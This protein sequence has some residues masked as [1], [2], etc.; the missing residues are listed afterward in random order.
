[1]IGNPTPYLPW[2]DV[3]S[4]VEGAH[5]KW[6]GVRVGHS[7]QLVI[8]IAFILGA[9]AGCKKGFE[10]INAN[11]KSKMA[12]SC[13]PTDSTR[14]QWDWCNTNVIAGSNIREVCYGQL[15][16]SDILYPALLFKTREFPNGMCLF[17]AG[18]G[19]NGTPSPGCDQII[20]RDYAFVSGPTGQN[21]LTECLSSGK[22]IRVSGALQDQ[23][24]EFVAHQP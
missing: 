3:L 9:S 19:S 1:M 22:V 4:W 15:V 17:A 24:T 10:P 14:F 21:L 13:L 16:S 18:N 23:R 5:P 20:N 11:D 12:A 7:G 6:E 8:A 2:W